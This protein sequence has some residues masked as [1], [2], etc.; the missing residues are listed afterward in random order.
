VDGIVVGQAYHWFD[1]VR[2][3]PEMVRVLR[4]G[5]RLGLLWNMFD[6]EVPWVARFCAVWD[7]EARASIAVQ[8]PDAPYDGPT[9]G[10][11]AAERRFFA[12]EQPVDRELLAS[13]LRSV[14]H[15]ILLPEEER[16]ALIA[17]AL[18]E[19]PAGRFAVPYVCDVW[20]ASKH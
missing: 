11:S 2:A 17:A 19:A 4:P 5:G 14:S 7:P 1:P 18:A 9:V 12:H 20:R 13:Q 3:L 10:L 16:E 8:I 6:D 15:F